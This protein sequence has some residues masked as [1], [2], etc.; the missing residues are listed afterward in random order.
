M[1]GVPNFTSATVIQRYDEALTMSSNFTT[2]FVGAFVVD[3]N[4]QPD[5]I[6][7]IK[8]NQSELSAEP[9]LKSEDMPGATTVSFLEIGSSYIL[10]GLENGHITAIKYT[11]DDRRGFTLVNECR[12][13]TLYGHAGSILSICD[14]REFGIALSAS[15]DHT[16]IIWDMTKHQNYPSYVRTINIEGPAYLVD[17]S[18]T[19]GDILLVNS[20]QGMKGTCDRGINISKSSSMLS[21]FTINGQKVMD[22]VC[23]PYISAA[24]FSSAPEGASVNVIATGHGL[25]TGVVRLWSTWDL[26]PVRDIPTYQHA[27]I[28]SITF[29]LDNL[30]LYIATEDGEVI[31]LENPK[32]HLST[33]TK[34]FMPKFSILSF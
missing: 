21:L 10:I 26:T 9:L 30:R 8:C 3:W 13:L 34:K 22:R 6:I 15:S 18:K 19:S 17:I 4:Q 23:E 24:A 5:Q 25:G 27:T 16:C 32:S 29:T 12:N 31:V 20:R 14:S 33:Q 1:C 11:Y 2:K 28:V 7:R